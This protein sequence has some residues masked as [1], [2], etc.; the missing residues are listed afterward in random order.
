MAEFSFG[1][2]GSTVSSEVENYK[3][4]PNGEN[5]YFP[6]INII[7]PLIISVAFLLYAL[8]LTYYNVG[9]S[10]ANRRIAKHQHQQ[11]QSTT[12]AAKRECF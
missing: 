10:G 9:G 6:G 7:W 11:Q 4:P 12:M 2:S 8:Q 3:R 1:S 5:N